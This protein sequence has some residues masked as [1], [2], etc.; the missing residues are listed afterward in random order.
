MHS[1]S[2]NGRCARV[3]L[4]AQSTHIH[5][6]NQSYIHTYTCMHT[7]IHNTYNQNMSVRAYWHVFVVAHVSGVKRLWTVATNGPIVYLPLI[8]VWRATVE[9]GMPKNSEKNLS[10]CHLSPPQIPHG[11]TT[12]EPGPPYWNVTWNGCE[13]RSSTG[14]LT[15]FVFHS[16]RKFLAQF[17][18]LTEDTHQNR[19]KSFI[20]SFIHTFIHSFIHSVSQ[21]L[22]HSLTHFINRLVLP[23]ALSGDYW[24]LRSSTEETT[25]VS[26]YAPSSYIHFKMWN[27]TVFHVIPFVVAGIDPNDMNLWTGIKWQ[28]SD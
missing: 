23:A 15:K 5:S 14:T 13:N 12:G 17:H 8:W 11:L 6:L 24:V 19:Q 18:S 27:A 16:N 4:R 26:P 22:S 7:H 9:W 21:S 25:R 3:A 10:Q 28:R 1:R 20:H 2:E